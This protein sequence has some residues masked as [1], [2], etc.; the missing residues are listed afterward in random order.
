MGARSEDDARAVT[1]DEVQRRWHERLSGR[2]FVAR[3]VMDVDLDGLREDRHLTV[4]RDDEAGTAER[5]MIRFDTPPSLRNVGLLYLE[6]QDRAND[7]F[8][9][10]PSARRVRRLP[11]E[12]VSENLYG[13]DPEFLGF[14]VAKSEPTEV[15][16]FNSVALGASRAYRLVER[17]RHANRRFDERTVWIDE[18]T[19][20]PLRTELRLAC[21]TVLIAET[22]EIREIQGVATPVRMRFA[23]PLDRV[24]VDLVI[25]AVDYDAGIPADVFS[26]FALT[27]SQDPGR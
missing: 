12:A 2:T 13:L 7:Y 25:E 19:S 8:L 4:V 27:K 22:L 14:G 11:A 16:S 21:E 1:P 20:I 6:Q 24:H 9:Y 10:R 17:A 5:V 26:V 15:T 3:V 18:A 23:R